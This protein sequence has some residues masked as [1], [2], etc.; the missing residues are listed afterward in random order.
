MAELLYVYKNNVYVNL[1]N[2][3][4]G[5]CVFC[6]RNKKD[7]VGESKLVLDRD[8]TLQELKDAID[9][10]DFTGYDELI[11][12][13]YGEPTCALENLLKTAAYFRSGHS[14]K[15]RL[16]TNGL[17]SLYNGRDI[18]PE[19]CSVID[20][21]SVSLNAPNAQRYQELVRPIYE[22]AFDA[23]LSFAENARKAGKEVVFSVVTV[24]SEEEIAQCRELAENMNIALKVRKYDKDDSDLKED[25]KVGK[26][27]KGLHHVS[28]K[29]VGQAEFHKTIDFYTNVLG[30][31]P[32][33]SWSDSEKTVVLL[34]TGSGYIEIASN[35]KEHLQQGA[36]YHVALLTDD[37]ERCI[38]AV[39]KAGYQVISGPKE[40]ILNCDRPYPIKTA[41]F[42]GP[43]GEEVEIF[44]EV[45]QG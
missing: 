16:N 17:G 15:I 2:K 25:F 7:G 21:F 41:F 24:L 13:G 10:F 30:L 3:C 44:Q 33:R 35:G 29:C 20:S 4:S 22:N 8:P 14:Q 27:V 12:C 40:K 39:R 37:T 42:I 11:F 26:L 32:A 43:T 6:V 9:A 45:E 31:L 19:L 38:Q 36:I 1:T 5:R 28:L 23:V 18:L 34:D